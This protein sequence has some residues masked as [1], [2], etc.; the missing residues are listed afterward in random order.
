MLA[1][2]GARSWFRGEARDRVLTLPEY[3]RAFTE[4]DLKAGSLPLEPLSQRVGRNYFPG[5]TGD[6]LIIQK[7]YYV[8]S[9]NT[10]GHG[11]PYSYDS[12]VPV[13]L[14]GASFVAGRYPSAASPA[15]IAPTLATILHVIRPSGAVGRVLTEAL[16][17]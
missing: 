5:R 6:V 9:D 10:T 3:A 13:I 12:N 7:P 15:D 4:E 2:R 17:H 16:A 8:S 14:W 1:S 11:S